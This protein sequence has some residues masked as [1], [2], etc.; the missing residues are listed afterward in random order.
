MPSA[1]NIVGK[2]GIAAL[3]G[4][5]V[6]GWVG[7]GW[8]ALTGFATAFAEPVGDVFLGDLINVSTRAT[9]GGLIKYV[10]M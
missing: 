8:G 6:A 3:A 2:T 4:A 9:C 10:A 7:A 5:R 1:G